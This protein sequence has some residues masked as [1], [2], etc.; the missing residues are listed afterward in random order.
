M[1][2]AL[3]Y[4]SGGP[5]VRV[6]PGA[7]G[8]HPSVTALPG[9]GFAVTFV[10]K[11]PSNTVEHVFVQEYDAAS[12]PIGAARKLVSLEDFEESQAAIAHLGGGNFVITYTDNVWDNTA[13]HRNL[14]VAQQLFGNG[15]GFARPNAL[16]DDAGQAL[17]SAHAAAYV[18]LPAPAEALALTGVAEPDPYGLLGV[19]W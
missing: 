13:G 16:P 9:G 17:S 18:A 2:S 8:Y 1:S 7:A 3:S 10:N 4:E 15:G 19:W 5:I 11:A 14:D 12:N 6:N